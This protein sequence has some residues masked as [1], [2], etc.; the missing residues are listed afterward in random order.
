MKCPYCNNEMDI[1]NIECDGRG[2][3][4]WSDSYHKRSLLSK[5]MGTDCIILAEAAIFGNTTHL[6][7]SCIKCKKIII[8]I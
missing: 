5:F 8:D 6:A 7:H 2:G 1:G 4:L 3:L